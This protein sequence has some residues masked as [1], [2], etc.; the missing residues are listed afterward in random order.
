MKWN[1]EQIERYAQGDMDPA[2]AEKLEQ[3]LSR[4]L[5]AQAPEVPAKRMW[6]NIRRRIEAGEMPEMEPGFFSRLMAWFTLPPSPLFRLAL[7]GA[8]AAL[9]VVVGLQVARNTPQPALAEAEAKKEMAEPPAADTAPVSAP[10]PQPAGRREEARAA[11]APSMDFAEAQ[12]M[13]AEASSPAEK[14]SAASARTEVERALEEQNLD[15]MIAA[16]LERQKEL[17]QS[18]VGTQAGGSAG[19]GSLSMAPSATHVSFAPEAASAQPSRRSMLPRMPVTSRE[20]FN[21][22]VPTGTLGGPDQNGFWD[23]SP[24]ARALNSRQWKAAEAEFDLASHKAAEPAERAFAVSALRLLSLPGQPLSD[25]VEDFENASQALAVQS[26]GRWQFFAANRV[27][28][29]S[30]GVVARMPGLRSEG[31]ALQLD[32]NF[33]RASFAAGTRF[34]RLSGAEAKVSGEN[35]SQLT[36]TEF[37]APRGADYLLKNTELRLK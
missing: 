22:K 11:K 19:A 10:A 27:A 36:E 29:Y 1:D 13:A 7:S 30:G 8:A 31:S 23:F 24:A 34:I 5:K 3:D 20:V 35:G 14:A 33:D 25:R 17:Q 26:A 15:T 32:L 6:E 21:D 4:L 2:Q 37:M 9:L 28:L 12:P 18:G 16:L